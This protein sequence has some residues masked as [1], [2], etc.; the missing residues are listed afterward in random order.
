MQKWH[1]ACEVHPVEVQCPECGRTHTIMTYYSTD[2][3]QRSR[4]RDAVY[5]RW[6]PECDRHASI[7]AGERQ[8]ERDAGII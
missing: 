6:C 5:D 3:A 7:Y 4:S 2:Y 8:A 1:D